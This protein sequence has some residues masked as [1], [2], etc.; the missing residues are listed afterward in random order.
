LIH[1]PPHVRYYADGISHFDRVR[2]ELL[3]RR[4]RAGA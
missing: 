2:D 4:S 1:V 3:A